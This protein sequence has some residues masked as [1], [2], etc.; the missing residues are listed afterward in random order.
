MRTDPDLTPLP[1]WKQRQR[2]LVAWW[3]RSR[4]RRR[5]AYQGLRKAGAR[6]LT[7]AISMVGATL[8]S[9]GVWS[10][11]APAGYVVAG[12]L[13]WAIQWNYGEEESDGS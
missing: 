10:V 5:T 7:L 8:I 2:A 3:R 13:V 11:Y 6:A 4:D 12:V 9:Y 1:V